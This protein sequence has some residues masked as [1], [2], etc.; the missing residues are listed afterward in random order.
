MKILL[1]ALPLQGHLSP[2]ATL[3]QALRKQGHDV[4]ICT[5]D[6]DN[7]RRILKAH[8]PGQG[9]ACNEVENSSRTCM[10][11]SRRPANAFPV[12]ALLFD[13]LHRL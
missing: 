9:S 6:T 2:V 1:A 7:A 13:F 11:T 3:G 4:T 8:A 12:A 5:S 10:N